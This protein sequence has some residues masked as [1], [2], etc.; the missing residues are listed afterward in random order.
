[1]KKYRHLMHSWIRTAEKSVDLY[2]E[3]CAF[4]NIK[5]FTIL[6]FIF[7]ILPPYFSRFTHESHDV[8]LLHLKSFSIM[9]IIDKWSWSHHIHNITYTAHVVDFL[10]SHQIR[11]KVLSII[12]KWFYHKKFSESQI[13]FFFLSTM[14]FFIKFV[15]L[16][17][18]WKMPK[19]FTKFIRQNIFKD[20]FKSIRLLEFSCSSWYHIPFVYFLSIFMTQM[21]TLEFE[22]S[23]KVR[24][25]LEWTMKTYAPDVQ[26]LFL[27]RRISSD[28]N[29]NKRYILTYSKGKGKCLLC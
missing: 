10:K 25:L 14:K 12:F 29:D 26:Y 16:R 27:S 20:E 24:T 18:S 9:H 1:M 2:S 7:F 28:S 19:I 15:Y 8:E 6:N 4:S 21:A 13:L 11:L 3:K 22:K 5:G 23:F 17:G